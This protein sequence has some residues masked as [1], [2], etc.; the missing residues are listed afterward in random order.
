MSRAESK[1]KRHIKEQRKQQPPPMQP[2]SFTFRFGINKDQIWEF[3]C[4]TPYF[5]GHRPDLILFSLEQKEELAAKL[6]K[7]DVNG[8]PVLYKQN[9]KY[10]IANVK[11]KEGRLLHPRELSTSHLKKLEEQK[12]LTFIQDPTI[13]PGSEVPEV[14]YEQMRLKKIYTEP[15]KNFPP[16]FPSQKHHLAVPCQLKYQPKE[17]YVSLEEINTSRIG[18]EV[19][20]IKLTQ[21][22]AGNLQY[23]LEHAEMKHL[24]QQGKFSAY[25]LPN[26]YFK[27]RLRYP[28]IAN[29]NQLYL[30]NPDIPV[31]EDDG[32]QVS[33]A[34]SKITY[35]HPVWLAQPKKPVGENKEISNNQPIL[36]VGPAQVIKLKNKK[37]EK[38]AENSNKVNLKLNFFGST[39]ITKTDSR[40]DKIATV[41][42]LVSGIEFR[43]FLKHKI[44]IDQRL[45]AAIAVLEA[46]QEDNNTYVQAH[47]DLAPKNI[48]FDGHKATFID[49]DFTQS[50]EKKSDFT[51]T[52]DYM[53]PR[54]IAVS[55]NRVDQEDSTIINPPV[56]H[57]HSQADKFSVGLILLEILQKT[58][59]GEKNFQQN[60]KK[61]IR[62]IYESINPS[63]WQQFLSCF[64]C[65]P[66]KKNKY[67]VDGDCLI[68]LT[69]PVDLKQFQ[70]HGFGN[71][72]KSI[73]KHLQD[74][75][76]FD[77][78]D[79]NK[80]DLTL[81]ET[82]AE[83]G[84]FRKILR[85]KGLENKPAVFKKGNA[86]YINAF[87]KKTHKWDVFIVSKCGK[88]GVNP[89]KFDELK[90]FGSDKQPLI[91]PANEVV[92]SL[93]S[94]Y[95]EICKIHLQ[96]AD[97]KPLL[98]TLKE[99]KN[100]RARLR[101]NLIINLKQNI[102]KEFL[103][104]KSNSSTAPI[105]AKELLTLIAQYQRGNTS[106][107][108]NRCALLIH[109]K[110]LELM[111]NAQK[112]QSSSSLYRFFSRSRPRYSTQE[113]EFYAQWF[114]HFEAFLFKNEIP[115]M[116]K[117]IQ[118]QEEAV[119]SLAVVPVQ[120]TASS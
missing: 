33:G 114:N 93:Y 27:L 117:Q 66:S 73:A 40:L 20:T 30:E 54:L 50:L 19:P 79:R 11:T 23:L 2:P 75:I 71:D 91:I 94:I 80:F 46:F 74:M 78:D 116:A 115:E 15:K 12:K 105:G 86:Y 60:R 36:V 99:K 6:K 8:R 69:R 113:R 118:E 13:L 55:A 5:T 45:D 37:N 10:F 24:Q 87:C 26:E 42:P 103:D 92:K 51:G 97:V 112:E 9:N 1:E 96:L 110:L 57:S 4:P 72:D 107:S 48:I 22:E 32:K 39:A 14:V 62:E 84:N 21:H 38:L 98:E 64:G 88:F 76:E 120:L 68:A 70:Y 29:D 77:F 119:A 18:K 111:K 41:E 67:Q 43:R 44:T 31:N 95:K 16:N 47:L 81:I 108:K 35:G 83:P 52:I 85:K 106:Y 28:L 58:N 63:L 59:P 104:A 101:E 17:R 34:F 109:Q 82:K 61:I 53:D 25:P 89:N 90:E 7:Y 56:L 102:R 100:Q 49:R 3:N 65:G